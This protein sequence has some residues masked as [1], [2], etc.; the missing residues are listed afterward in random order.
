VFI[1]ANA[2]E[3]FNPL[4]TTAMD[5]NTTYTVIAGWGNRSDSRDPTNAGAWWGYRGAMSN[6]SRSDAPP[7]PNLDWIGQHPDYPDLNSASLQPL[8]GEQWNANGLMLIRGHGGFGGP[9]TIRIN[10]ENGTNTTFADG[11]VKWAGGTGP[12]AFENQ[13]ELWNGKMRW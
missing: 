4:W 5:R 13:S 6:P 10:H 12:S 9:G 7:M 2:D 8:I 1:C 3:A 11:H